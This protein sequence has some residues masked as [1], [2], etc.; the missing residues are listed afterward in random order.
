MAGPKDQDALA[1]AW[2]ES[3]L[4]SQAESEAQEG[5][6]E[7]GWTP[8]VSSSLD[9]GSDR[10]LNQEEIDNLLG[11]SL[12]EA[13]LGGAGGIRAI[14]DSSIVSYERLP[15]LE[16]VFDRLVRLLTVS[17]R[18]FFSDNVEVSLDGITSVRFGD[19]VS[20]IPLPA[21][22]AVFKAEEWENNGLVFVDSNLIYLIIDVLLGGKRG[23]SSVRM[24]G[25]PYTTIEINLV[26]RMLD[27]VLMDAAEAFA[28]L[29]PVSF[30]MDRIE[31]NPRFASI[32][33]PANAAIL[34]ELRLDMEG[35]G[36][37]I[38][39]LLPFATIEPIR[40]LLLQS[41]M[42]EKLGRDPTW[43]NHLAT[44]VF[45][46]TL[47]LEA[48]LHQMEMP[49]REI[50]NIKKG[51]TILFDIKN[52][53]IVQVRCGEQQVTEGRMGRIGDNIAVQVLSPLIRSTT[54]MAVFDQGGS[55]KKDLA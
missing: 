6:A 2:E 12:D 4:A 34:V 10:L 36:G 28:P 44:E 54:T 47:E 21:I 22:L 43:E 24:D 50:V 53:P 11:F 9:V 1:D 7:S 49:L 5:V 55:G 3:L 20:S 37:I 26:R 25:R 31:T 27:V 30:T 45:G 15:M 17:L 14:V 39:I 42:G 48:V 38:E 51:D 18:N 19:Y 33:R 40:D 46:A 32:T 35:R 41:F 23:N 52:D 16:I 13:S 29:S 8:G